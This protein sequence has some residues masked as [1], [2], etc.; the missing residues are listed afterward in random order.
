VFMRDLQAQLDLNSV[1]TRPVGSVG[2]L[3]FI[4]DLYAQLDPSCVYT[5]P[6]GSVGSL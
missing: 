6:V 1:H 4:R 2:S 5:R 3:L